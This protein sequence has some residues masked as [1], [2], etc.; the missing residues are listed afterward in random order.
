MSIITWPPLSFFGPSS[1][2]LPLFFARRSV[3]EKRRDE[4][5]IT[6]GIARSFFVKYIDPAFVSNFRQ[7][8]TEW[9]GERDTVMVI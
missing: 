3:E 2:L 7:R 8:K 4:K 1:S 6:M 5:E 9:K